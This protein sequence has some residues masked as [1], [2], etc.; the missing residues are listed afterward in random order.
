MFITISSKKA[1]GKEGVKNCRVQPGY[2]NG[3]EVIK[4]RQSKQITVLKGPPVAELTL[5]RS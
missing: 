5:L 3:R 4:G 2:Y 1:R